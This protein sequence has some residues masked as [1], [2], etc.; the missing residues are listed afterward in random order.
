MT[1]TEELPLES[2]KNIASQENCEQIFFSEA[3]RVISFRKTSGTGLIRINVYWTTGTVGTCI[4]HPRQGKTQLFRRNIDLATLREIFRNPRLHTGSGYYKENNNSTGGMGSHFLHQDNQCDDLENEAQMQM[5]RL[6]KELERI[7][8]EKARLQKILNTFE[9]ERARKRERERKRKAE[10]AA[11]AERKRVVQKRRLEKMALELKRSNRGK[12]ITYNI[13]EGDHVSKCFDETVTSMAC[14]GRTTIML[15]ESGGH[16][17]TS[18]LPKLLHNKLNSRQKSLPPPTYV[19]LGS[20]NRYYVKFKDGKSEWVG[21]DKMT[22]LLNKESRIVKTVAF[23]EDWDSY[24]VVFEDGWYSACGIP[25]GL[26]DVL[27]RRQRRGDLTSVSLGA[28]GE[29]FIR[30]RNGRMW[31]GGI[32]SEN[33]SIINQYRGRIQFI[34]FCGDNDAFVA[35]YT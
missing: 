2:V 32:N 11:E 9:E 10:E 16:A 26:D 8:E 4:D 7:N 6:D 25:D 1:T 12:H 31:W 24:F 28:K 15:Y 17:W 3:S 22:E 29:Y 33:L 18:G 34:D 21:S 19:A 27:K 20:M 30:A 35:R 13:F 23:G 5:K 14:G